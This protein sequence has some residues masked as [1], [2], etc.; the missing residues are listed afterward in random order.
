M[1]VFGIPIPKKFPT[2]VGVLVGVVTIVALFWSK[3]GAVAVNG[4][5]GNQVYC[6]G[7][8]CLSGQDKCTT[9]AIGGP[10]AVFS[11]ETFTAQCPSKK[12]C[13]GGT[14]TDGPCLMDFP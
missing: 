7:V 10:S 3:G 11:K 2:W 9:G 14:R 1:K 5:A 12:P 6:P 13:A 4:C 8:G